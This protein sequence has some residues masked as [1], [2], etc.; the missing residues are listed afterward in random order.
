AA[1]LRA[2]PPLAPAR[3]ATLGRR[4]E[5]SVT[6]GVVG[7]RR[8]ERS[9][10]AAYASVTVPLERVVAR[11]SADAA[12]SAAEREAAADVALESEGV[13]DAGNASDASGGDEPDVVLPALSPE[14][15]AR[16][17]RDSVAAA[18]NAR[19]LAEREGDL[20]AL[21]TRARWSALM[22]E[23]RVRAARSR[24][25][26]LHLQPTLDDPY[27]YSTIGG[28]G[29]LLEAQATFRLNRLVF[30]DEEVAIER[31]RVLRERVGEDRAER[32]TGRLIRWHRALSHERN[33]PEP[34]RRARAALARE[35]AQMEL[36][37]LT[38]GWFGERVRRL[39]LEASPVERREP[40]PKNPAE[41]KPAPKSNRTSRPSALAGLEARPV[42]ATS[43]S[44]CLPKL[45]TDS[46]TFCG[47][48]MR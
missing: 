8:T 12:I 33:D 37:V 18:G 32:V 9:E 10:L 48:S 45:A 13:R 42:S 29:L 25:D 24:D 21:A 2:E 11:R 44:P 16:L 15:L 22:P 46:R 43:A 14:L 23:V 35:E 47:A 36:D 6:L 5:A 26:S 17:A 39:G 38:D 19:H 30:A 28:D 4:G 7:E 20:D 40:V 41:P 27:R 1:P 31:I 3:E 34:E